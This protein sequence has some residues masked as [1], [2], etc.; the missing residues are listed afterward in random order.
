MRT[1]DEVIFFLEAKQKTE[2][3][4][5]RD[6]A[7]QHLREF[8]ELIKMWNDKL[9]KE[10][11]NP[12]LTWEQLKRMEGKPVWIA[13]NGTYCWEIIQGVYDDGVSFGHSFYDRHSFDKE[14]QAYRKEK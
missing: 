13:N 11:E 4:N 8:K 14:W 5:I 6:D 2:Y 10:Q 3:W 12:P 1:I 7:I 9:D